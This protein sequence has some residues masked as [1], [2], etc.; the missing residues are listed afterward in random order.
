MKGTK[1]FSGKGKTATS[2]GKGEK[3]H[4]VKEIVVARIRMGDLLVPILGVLRAY[5][6]LAL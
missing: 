4:G 5:M 6:S 1:S 3:Y 2:R